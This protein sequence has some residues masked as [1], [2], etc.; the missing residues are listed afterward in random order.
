MKYLLLLLLFFSS[1]SQACRCV[2][3]RGVDELTKSSSSVFVGEVI[4]IERI[5]TLVQHGEEQ[6]YKVTLHPVEVFKGKPKNKY[7]FKAYETF[8]SRFADSKVIS[9]DLNLKMEQKFLVFFEKGK[10]ITMGW[11]SENVK[12]SWEYSEKEYRKELEKSL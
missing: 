6:K 11:C 4:G 10:E 12:A 5:G 7:R 1:T 9:C 2:N 3:S 8:N